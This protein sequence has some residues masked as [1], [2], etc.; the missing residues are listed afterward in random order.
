[1]NK[2]GKTDSNSSIKNKPP[3]GT[4]SS[5]PSQTSK[6]NKKKKKETNQKQQSGSEWKAVP[7]K[8]NES[9][10]KHNDDKTYHWCTNHQ[11]WTIHK[12]E[13][14]KGWIPRHQ[15]GDSSDKKRKAQPENKSVQRL[16]LA[17]QALVVDRDEDS[18]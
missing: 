13:D 1:L 10:V 2:K 11:A 3:Q 12:P 16:K 17:A 18:S 6:T 7:P 8:A 15:Q 9:K 4:A 14:C 5:N